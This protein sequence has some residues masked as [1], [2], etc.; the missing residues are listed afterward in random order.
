[1]RVRVSSDCAARDS[2]HLQVLGLSQSQNA[3][4]CHLYVDFKDGAALRQVRR[5]VPARM[6]PHWQTILQALVEFQAQA[7]V[8][9]ASDG[10]VKDGSCGTATQALADACSGTSLLTLLTFLSLLTLHV[11]VLPPACA[12][13]DRSPQS[14][15]CT[16]CSCHPTRCSTAASPHTPPV[17]PAKSPSP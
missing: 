5:D 11:N 14:C 10:A 3:S 4:G 9:A 2:V 6:R 12:A 8:H 1:M 17:L 15:P 13:C 7:V 16:C